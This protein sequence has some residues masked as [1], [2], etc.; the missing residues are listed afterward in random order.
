MTSK[1]EY[2]FKF[3]IVDETTGEVVHSDWTYF[4]T[5]DEFGGCESVDIHVAAMLRGWQ[6][7]ARAEYERR[8]YW[9]ECDCCGE[10]RA[11]LT[12][13]WAFGIETFA[14]DE[15]REGD[16]VEQAQVN[17]QFGVGA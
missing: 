5:I 8:E 9:K 11:E 6:R 12:R 14:C 16:R 10:K 15:C 2:R 13:C 3:Q 7:H 17:S 1:P 4:T